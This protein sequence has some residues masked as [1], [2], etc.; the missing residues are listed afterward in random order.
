M[1]FELVSDLIAVMADLRRHRP[2]QCKSEV[3]KPL[4]NIPGQNEGI[5][6]C[7]DA[8]IDAEAAPSKASTLSPDI[9]LSCFEDNQRN[10]LRQTLNG[11]SKRLFQREECGF[12]FACECHAVWS[13]LQCG[14][15][16]SHSTRL[17]KQTAVKEQ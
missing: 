13:V 3:L 7:I 11:V 12:E 15:I 9:P 2:P 10:D 5:D 8:A 17:P 16:S 4:C 6:R 1:R 14:S